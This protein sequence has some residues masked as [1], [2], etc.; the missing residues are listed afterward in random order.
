MARSFTHLRLTCYPQAVGIDPGLRPPAIQFIPVASMVVS[1]FP[2]SADVRIASLG[3][4]CL[5]GLRRSAVVPVRSALLLVLLVA[6]T[7][8]QAQTLHRGLGPAPDSLDPHRAQSLSAIN[9]LRDLHEGL[10]SFDARAELIPGLAEHWAVSEDGLR[11]TFWLRE[12]ARWSDG[13]PLTA[14]DVVAGWRRLLDPATAS[15]QAALLDRVRSAIEIRNGRLPPE[16]LGIE[17]LSQHQLRVHLQ[18][19]TVWLAEL[20]TQPATFPWPG[21]G[22]R[23]YSGPFVLADQVPGA[24]L[25]LLANQEWHAADQVR[26]EAVRWHV[27][28]EPTVELNRY[29]AGELHI[30]ETIPPSRLDWL[31][32]QFRAELRIAPYLGSFF[33]SFNLARSP[34]RDQPDLRRALSLAIDRDLLTERVLGSG[35]L[36]AERLIPPGMPGWPGRYE[37]QDVDMEA[38]R[39]Q[40]RELYRSAGYS[41]REPLTVEL[42]VNTS[43]AHRRMSAAVAAMWREHLGVRTRQVSEEW[44]VFVA[45]RRHGRLTQ[46][47]RGGWIADWRDPANFLQLFVSDSPLNY[48]FFSDP[49]FDELMQEAALDIGPD[50]QARLL[51]AEQRVLD[52]QVIIPLYYYVSRHLVKPEVRGFED[53]LMDVHLSRWLELE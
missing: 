21:D 35:E 33:L 42:R 18:R 23:R 49:T 6:V 53:N 45:N 16:R 30:T 47:V 9:V 46:I 10:V 52:A 17:A 5:A 7:L 41:T 38:R 51:E 27:I 4:R 29:R 40:A 1:Q 26:L 32:E 22:A 48:S 15:P 50:R 19:P 20:L 28:E 8:V 31:R 37:A 39:A 34:F 43:L 12:E 44:K 2:I 24:H 13:S 36:P 3:E 25:H 11:W 14:D